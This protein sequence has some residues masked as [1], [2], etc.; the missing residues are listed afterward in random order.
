MPQR[1]PGPVLSTPTFGLIVVVSLRELADVL[2]DYQVKRTRAAGFTWA[3]IAAA[4]GVSPPSRPQET[5][6]QARP[7]GRP[8]HR[9]S[10]STRL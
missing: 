1:T 7:G 8:V 10:R 2:D 3:Q 5:R 6:R 9:S 4:V